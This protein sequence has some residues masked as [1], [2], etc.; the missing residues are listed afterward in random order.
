MNVK[1]KKILIVFLIITLIC[2]IFL[3]TIS[4][5]YE[6]V[7][8]NID[9]QDE[10]IDIEPE[11]ENK[12]ENKEEE[13]TESIVQDEKEQESEKEEIKEENNNKENIETDSV[14]EG[15]PQ[16]VETE[17]SI[18]MTNV[19]LDENESE[20]LK[21][22]NGV[23]T[24]STALNNNK[25]LDVAAGSKGNNANIQLWDNVNVPQQKFQV[26]YNETGKYYQI[27][28]VNSGKSLDVED[29]GTK[30]GT[31]VQ[32]YTAKQIEAQQWILKSA[33]DGYY[34][35][36]SKCN[37]LY[38]DVANG[39][40]N[41]G[42][43][44]QMYEGN[45]TTAQKFKF[46]KIKEL[47]T[48][49]ISEQL[50][51][52]DGVYT[53]STALN[54]N[55]VL[56]VSGGSKE[57]NANIQLWDNVNVPQQKFQVKYNET[58]KYYQIISVNSGKSLDVEDSGTK[59][60]TNVQQYTAKQIEAQQWILKSAGDGYYY[61][62]SKCNGLYLDVANGAANNGTNIQM[63][64]GNQTTAQKFKFKKVATLANDSYK[65]AIKSDNNKYFDIA[66]GSGEERANL[67]IWEKSNVNQQIFK[68]EYIDDTYCKII[69]KH[70]GKV[71]TAES[72]S[73]VQ[74]S[75]INGI[76][77]QWSIEVTEDGYYKVKSRETGKYL[78]VMNGSTVNGTKVQTYTGN[79]TSAQKFKFERIVRLDGIDV[80]EHQGLINWEYVKRAGIDFAIIRVG[81]GQHST[82]KDKYFE[83][84]YNTAR[85][86]GLSVG[87]YLYSYA[88]S[89]EDARKEAYNCLNWLNGRYLDY[90]VFY[91][92]EDASQD[93]IDRQ[94]ITDMAKAFCEILNNAGYKTGV[95]ANKNW[96]T[97]KIYAD[98]LPGY[99]Q[100]WLAHYT[101][102]AN[103]SSDYTGYY[104]IWQYTSVGQVMGIQTNV[105]RDIEYRN[106]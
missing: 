1:I 95:Y 73:V 25:V 48:E 60:G 43:N 26:K 44:I 75:Y 20:Q 102:D 65:I 55:K 84:N 58:G 72:G 46:T 69:A 76:S 62:I 21:E 91:D 79:N 71:L 2:P 19:I 37:G 45:Q 56:D 86:V 104:N 101:Y 24:I 51:E 64:K 96:F 31:N 66:G 39:V 63:Y 5:S 80:S 42:T 10:E 35:I 47:E 18:M 52:G 27:I 59:N 53:I 12:E 57:N 22:G 85:N 36:I 87:S 98:Q 83:I 40:A 41:N 88:Q 82:Q 103:K 28:S 50:T 68:I 17:T 7:K 70:S 94:T 33:G 81:Y 34:Y 6:E 3:S 67:Q 49:L 38:L 23:Y 16:E 77:Q 74:R 97:N 13:K 61:I 78:D 105:D 29:S 8:K 30:N 90:P 4:M 32:Q 106:K 92:L 14:Q 93:W 99:C 100:I 54:N 89:V 11:E 9:Y 15:I